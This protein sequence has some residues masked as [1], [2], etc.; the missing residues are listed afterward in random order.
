[1]LLAMIAAVYV[2]GAGANGAMTVGKETML[3]RE[4]SLEYPPCSST[5]CTS[6][7]LSV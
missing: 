7:T 1:M 4:K 3:R 2:P 5:P 6:V